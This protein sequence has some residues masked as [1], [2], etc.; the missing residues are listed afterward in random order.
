MCIICPS[1]P[2]FPLC[3]YLLFSSRPSIRYITVFPYPIHFLSHICISLL[4]LSFLRL[5]QPAFKKF[6][7][8]VFERRARRV[9]SNKYRAAAVPRS[10]PTE[11]TFQHPNFIFR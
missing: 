9:Q 1:F 6:H 3:L 2:L 8:I 10:G 11:I 4:V 7:V 5:Q